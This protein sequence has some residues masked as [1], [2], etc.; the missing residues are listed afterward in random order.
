MRKGLEFLIEQSESSWTSACQFAFQPACLARVHGRQRQAMVFEFG[1]FSFEL[2]DGDAR[3]VPKG[4]SKLKPQ[5]S[6]LKTASAS[7]Q[8]AEVRGDSSRRFRAN[9]E[10]LSQGN[11]HSYRGALSNLATHLQ[12]K[13]R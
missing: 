5:N 11:A 3:P 12:L 7:R 1:V 9:S 6:K 13:Q 8:F 10:R 4:H 2:A